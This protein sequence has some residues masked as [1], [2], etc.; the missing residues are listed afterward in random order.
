MR[1]EMDQEKVQQIL[2]KLD[3]EYGITKEGFLH[4]EAWQLLLA[5]RLSAQSTDQQVYAVLP[6]L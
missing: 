4:F 1:H 6:R 3:E 2:S 5:I